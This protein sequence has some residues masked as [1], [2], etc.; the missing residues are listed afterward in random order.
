MS[1][2]HLVGNVKTLNPSI[3]RVKNATDAGLK[4]MIHDRDIWHAANQMLKHHGKDASVTAARRADELFKGGDLD[5]A[6]VWRRI[7]AAI[8]D[9]ARTKRAEGERVN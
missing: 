4:R 1:I 3:S 9:L 7:L 6:T 5:G 8:E 2:L